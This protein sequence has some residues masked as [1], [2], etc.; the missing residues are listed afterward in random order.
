MIGDG[1]GG[2]PVVVGN[3][4]TGWG[5]HT[6]Q[7]IPVRVL[8][9]C[10]AASLSLLPLRGGNATLDLESHAVGAWDAEARGIASDLQ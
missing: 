4:G 3:D 9:L 7:D 5:Q 8:G 2:T 1:A 10:R 6:G